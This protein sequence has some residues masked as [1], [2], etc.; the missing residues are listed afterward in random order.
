MKVKI[1]PTPHEFLNL[2]T[3]LMTYL[4][5]RHVNLKPVEQI[6]KCFETH[7]I[8]QPS[9]VKRFYTRGTLKSILISLFFIVIGL[10]H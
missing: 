8:I 6:I 1:T 4:R 2:N 9:R 7:C 3:Y 5:L 10:D